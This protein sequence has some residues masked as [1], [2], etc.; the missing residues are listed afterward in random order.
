MYEKTLP[1]AG[2]K[3]YM[4]FGKD[5]WYNAEKSRSLLFN[6]HNRSKNYKLTKENCFHMVKTS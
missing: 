3:A 1:A 4:A 5:E 2:L 6:I